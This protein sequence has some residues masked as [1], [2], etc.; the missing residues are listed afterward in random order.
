MMGFTFK[1]YI[2]AKTQN[3]LIDMFENVRDRMMGSEIDMV[4]TRMKELDELIESKSPAKY[5]DEVCNELDTIL[6][7]I[8][9][10]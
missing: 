10:N 2:M 1:E 8:A 9:K 4:T 7:S 3:E 5:Q 6:T